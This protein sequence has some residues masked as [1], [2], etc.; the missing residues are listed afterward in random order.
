MKIK[1]TNFI[2][3]VDLI[4]KHVYERFV[5]S[6]SKFRDIKASGRVIEI[7]ICWYLREYQKL[8]YAEIKD[9]MKV[10][11]SQTITNNVKK[12]KERAILPLSAERKLKELYEMHAKYVGKVATIT[13]EVLKSQTLFI[14][15]LIY[16]GCEVNIFGNIVEPE[17]IYEYLAEYNLPK[18]NLEA[19][20]GIFG[21]D[22]HIG[23]S[24]SYCEMINETTS[25]Q[26]V[27][28]R[29]GE[30]WKEEVYRILNCKNDI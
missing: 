16:S 9:L 12:F 18:L 1:K 14:T 19:G 21:A 10:K 6:Y 23:S 26:A 2:P 15:G 30:L 20:F 8:S 24:L 22:L 25:C 28:C 3:Y 7:G 4:S 29:E 13:F 5:N 17:E 27:L 11:N